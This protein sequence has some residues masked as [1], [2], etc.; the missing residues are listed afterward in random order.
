VSCQGTAPRLG[1][2]LTMSPVTIILVV[3]LLFLL[4]GGGYSYRAGWYGGSPYGGYGLGVM[5]VLIVVLLV[6]LVMGRI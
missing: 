2:Y 3:I 4:L 1:S 6:L 5:G